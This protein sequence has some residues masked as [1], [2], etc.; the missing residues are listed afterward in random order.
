[1]GGADIS[2]PFGDVSVSSAGFGAWDGQGFTGTIADLVIL[3]AAIAAIGLAVVTATSRTVAQ[4]VA[5]RALSGRPTAPRRGRPP[6]RGSTDCAEE[7]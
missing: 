2:T 7:G 1:M 6:S 5:A 3:A 4:A